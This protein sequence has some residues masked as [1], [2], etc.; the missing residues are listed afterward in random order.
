MFWYYRRKHLPFPPWNTPKTQ[1]VRSLS[2]PFSSCCSSFHIQ[3][4]TQ[5]LILFS[6]GSEKREIQSPFLYMKWFFILLVFRILTQRIFAFNMRH[7]S[8][9]DVRIESE[10]P[11]TY[12]LYWITPGPKPKPYGIPQNKLPLL[13]FSN[14]IEKL[15][16]TLGKCCVSMKWWIP[17]VLYDGFKCS[18]G[19]HNGKIYSSIEG[20]NIRGR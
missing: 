8:S 20:E 19:K 15:N 18:N 12:S 4:L 1:T 13:R 11:V 6:I 17:S 14:R 16:E 5:S 9:F 7:D 2:L 10:S 3:S